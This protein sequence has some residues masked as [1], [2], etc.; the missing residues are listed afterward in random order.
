MVPSPRDSSDYCRCMQAS[1]EGTRISADA[2]AGRVGSVMAQNTH[3]T[4][5]EATKSGRLP[6]FIQQEEARGVGPADGDAIERVIKAAVRRPRSTGR[7]SR[8]ACGGDSTGT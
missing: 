8:S 4:L 5:R 7:T 2:D 1:E 3:L 6:E